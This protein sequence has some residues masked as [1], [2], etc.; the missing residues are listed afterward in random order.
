MWAL[1][2][3]DVILM[4]FLA[5]C[6]PTSSAVLKMISVLVI[7]LRPQTFVCYISPVKKTDKCVTGTHLCDAYV[8]VTAEWLSGHEAIR[9][10]QGGQYTSH[11][12]PL[13]GGSIYKI[14][15]APLIHSN[16]CR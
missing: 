3:T 13:N 14:H 12:D 2:L 8:G 16:S 5:A 4:E 7:H 15:I 11:I 9:A 6:K 10:N 1:T